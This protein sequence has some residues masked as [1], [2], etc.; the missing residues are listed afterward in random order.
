[1]KI[2]RIIYKK[3]FPLSPFVNEHIG[4]EIQVDEGDDVDAVMKHAKDLVHS[5]HNPQMVDVHAPPLETVVNL[6]DEPV[7][8]SIEDANSIEELSTL[9]K[10]L[11]SHLMPQYMAK[12]K[13]LT[14]NIKSQF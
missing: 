7:I 2:D 1:M 12:L 11:P 8:N 5:W 3:V 9:K 14:E 10:N 6:R 13:I 4:V